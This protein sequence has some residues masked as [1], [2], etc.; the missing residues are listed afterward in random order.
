[1]T[2]S[3]LLAILRSFGSERSVHVLF[4][5]SVKI[6]LLVS[7]EFHSLSDC[8]FCGTCECFL[9]GGGFLLTAFCFRF[10]VRTVRSLLIPCGFVR[11]GLYLRFLLWSLCSG[12]RGVLGFSSSGLCDKKE[13]KFDWTD[14]FGGEGFVQVLFCFLWYFF[15]GLHVFLFICKLIFLFVCAQVILSVPSFFAARVR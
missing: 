8:L 2:S 15:L 4:F 7:G 11:G 3:S 6:N 9:L 13:V 14:I 5:I 10:I 12:V 1:M